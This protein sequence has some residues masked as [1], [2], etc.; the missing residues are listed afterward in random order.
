V[1]KFTDPVK[2]EVYRPLEVLPPATLNFSEKMFVFDSKVTKTISIQLKANL[3]QVKGELRLSA[4]AGWS[5]TLTEQSFDLASKAEEKI[6]EARLTPGKDAKDGK[7]RAEVLINGK[8]YSKSIRRVD[9]EH[10]P[11]QFLL[12]EAEADLVTIDLKKAGTNIGYIP[13]AGDD[14]AT[15]LKQIG[16]NVTILS[17]EQLRHED[18]SKFSAVVTGI[19]AYNTSDKLHAHKEKLMKYIKNGGNLIVQ[20]NTNSRVGPLQASIGPYPF[21]ISRERVTNENAAVFFKNE[22][23]P[24]LNYPNKITV[25]D[26]EGW[27]QERGIYFASELDKNY[28]TVLSMNDPNEK[29]NEGSLIIAKYGKGNFVYTGLAFFRELPA[30]IPGAYR[31]FANLLSLPQNK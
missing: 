20:Y 24:V 30:G 9:Y 31:L 26:F 29:S 7:L 5:I 25:K 27:V 19:R 21:T 16:Y 6:F 1:N 15:C 3:A 17:D 10:I 4:P 23:H 8:S 28:E 13:G 18:L 22:K 11:L 14:V 2:G 12:S